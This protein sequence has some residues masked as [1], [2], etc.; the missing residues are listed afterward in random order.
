MP[1]AETHYIDVEG[2]AALHMYSI[3]ETMTESDM[4]T[5]RNNVFPFLG[6][7]HAGSVISS[8]D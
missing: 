2:L 3:I 5:I 1:E 7:Y 8:G 6:D 4:Y